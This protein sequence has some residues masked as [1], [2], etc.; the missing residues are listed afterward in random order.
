MREFAKV[1]S[2]APEYMQKQLHHC[3]IHYRPDTI[4]STTVPLVQQTNKMLI[5]L[6][7]FY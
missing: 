4:E 7:K 3:Y 5:A 6:K 2:F 1:Y